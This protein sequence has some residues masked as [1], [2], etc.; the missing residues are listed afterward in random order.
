M[1]IE[2]VFPPT[3]RYKMKVCMVG[4]PSVGK[5]SLVR[6]YVHDM[7]A[8]HYITTLGAKVE[9]REVDIPHPATGEVTHIDMTLWDIMGHQ[10]LLG[11][12]REAYFHGARGILAVCDVTRRETLLRL[13]DWMQ[14][15]RHVAGAVPVF[16]LAN[17]VDLPEHQVTEADV[18]AFSRKHDSPY[19]MTSAKTGDGV[20][21][22][23]EEL[24]QT[25]LRGD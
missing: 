18:A 14:A 8:D 3:R 7:F 10:Q 24:A 5:T 4:D 20:V 22:S 15:V 19:V 23:F 13:P 21:D 12:L 17:K 11:M 25:V 2:V 6:R 16:I 1:A 9:K